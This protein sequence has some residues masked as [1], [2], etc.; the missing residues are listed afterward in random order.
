MEIHFQ[1]KFLSYRC[2]INCGWNRDTGKFNVK[3]GIDYVRDYI[4]DLPH[5]LF[6]VIANNQSLPFYILNYCRFK[7]NFGVSSIRRKIKDNT[8]I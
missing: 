1:E 4:I 5:S 7:Q 3:Q 2:F 8:K 6:F